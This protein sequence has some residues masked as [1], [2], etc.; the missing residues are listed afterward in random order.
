MEPTHTTSSSSLDRNNGGDS[1]RL[2][3]DSTLPVMANPSLPLLQSSFHL[4]DCFASSM[5]TE[6]PISFS[7]HARNLAPQKY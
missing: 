6:P 2:P 5:A 4:R 3:S 1:N 7:T